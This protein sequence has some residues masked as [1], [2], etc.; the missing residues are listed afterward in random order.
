MW[1][2]GAKDYAAI[3]EGIFIDLFQAIAAQILVRP[4]LDLL[5]I[6]CGSGIFCQLASWR[7]AR[8]SGLDA[9]E[10]FLAI[11]RQRLPE[12]DFRP[13]EM[14]A[15]PYADGRFDLVTGLNSFQFAADTVNALREARRV[16]RPGGRV[17]IAIF[18]RPDEV[19]SAR[20]MD[21][22]SAL[23][24]PPPPGTKTPFSLSA[25]G[26]LEA[27]VL[28]A[29]LQPGPMQEVDCLWQYPDQQTI[30]RGFLS[31]G[32]AARAIQHV[33]QDA[34]SQ[35]ILQASAPFVTR[36]GGYRL[37]VKARYLVARPAD[38]GNPI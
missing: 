36:A 33:G 9:T 38:P 34:V 32:P 20:I 30:L 27:A 28:E 16:T 1:G 4:G 21:A 18:G 3:Q 6:G 10:P 25:D 11:A 31:A 2:P 14:E 7:G 37:K 23:L 26:A 5:D 19:D 8:V 17:V 29:G 15:L 13:G 12:A 35:A 22:V 24:P